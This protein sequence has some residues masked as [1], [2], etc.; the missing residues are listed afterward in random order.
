MNHKIAVKLDPHD[1]LSKSTKVNQI[2]FLISLTFQ[3]GL[4]SAT[5][6]SLHPLPLHCSGPQ[7]FCIIHL[8]Y[9]HCLYFF[10]SF[11][12]RFVMD[13]SRKRSDIFQT[14]IIRS[15]TDTRTCISGKKLNYSLYKNKYFKQ[16]TWL[17]FNQMTKIYLLTVMYK[18]KHHQKPTPVYPFPSN[19]PAKTILLMRRHR[20]PIITPASTLIRLPVISKHATVKIWRAI[21]RHSIVS[22]RPVIA[23][24]DPI[25]TSIYRP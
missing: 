7:W 13:F 14:R 23:R 2:L 17:S 3:S 12:F 4:I 8:Y 16:I 1:L 22:I 18:N 25:K 20:R 5:S 21:T 15:P 6:Y 19:P 11:I 24:Y 9:L 10:I